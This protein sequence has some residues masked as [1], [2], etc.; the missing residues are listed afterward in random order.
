MTVFL[1][2]TFY[3]AMAL[4]GLIVEVLFGALGLIPQARNA[5]V[6]EPSLTLNYTTVLNVL[7]LALAGLLLIRAWRTGGFAMLAM[8]DRAPAMSPGGAG[9]RH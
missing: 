2:L 7:F 6:A 4:A 9:H 8:M 5:L 1:F 3:A